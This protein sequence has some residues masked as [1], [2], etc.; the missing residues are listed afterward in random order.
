[1]P[2]S[3]VLNKAINTVGSG[4]QTINSSKSSIDRNTALVKNTGSTDSI[5][6]TRDTIKS[7]DKKSAELDT[8]ADSENGL[9]RESSMLAGFEDKKEALSNQIVASKIRNSVVQ[10]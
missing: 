7:G 3:S 6:A 5:D 4:A 1:M 8:T 2:L 9:L 10:F